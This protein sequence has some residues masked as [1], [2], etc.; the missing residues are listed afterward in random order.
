MSRV[1]LHLNRLGRSFLLLA[2]LA[3]VAVAPGCAKPMGD[4]SGKVTYKGNLLPYGSVTYWAAD[5]SGWQG[6][7]G[8][9]GSYSIKGIPVGPA[10]ISVISV[11]PEYERVGKEL[12][13]KAR[14]K[15]G[16]PMTAADMP[17]AADMNKWRKSPEKYANQETSGLEFEVKAGQQ[18]HD[19][20]LQ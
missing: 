16:K 13:T 14:E 1:S 10:K 9:D 2:L 6:G 3:W 7:I 20:D 11:D 12:V 18:V 17:K 15:K 4:V 8:S 5:G 19:I